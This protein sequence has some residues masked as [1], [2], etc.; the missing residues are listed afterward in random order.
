MRQ[1]DFSALYAQST[2][3]YNPVS[4]APY[5]ANIIDPSTFD[6]RA[7]ALLSYMPLPNLS[8]NAAGLPNGGPNSNGQNTRMH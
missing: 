2:Q 5:P 1:D 8:T 7:K 6:S 3:L 4:G